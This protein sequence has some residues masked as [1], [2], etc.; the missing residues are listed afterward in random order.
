M[1]V[2]LDILIVDYL[3]ENHGRATKEKLYEHF[4]EWGEPYLYDR[5]QVLKKEGIIAE[6]IDI[7]FLSR[8]YR[9]P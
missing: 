5:L 8:H 3:R 2:H 4:N 6:R 1:T 9:D 7:F